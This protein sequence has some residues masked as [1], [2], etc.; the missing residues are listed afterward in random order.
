MPLC[1]SKA[2]WIFVNSLYK[3]MGMLERCCYPTSTY[4]LSCPTFKK[5]RAFVFF[6]TC[7]H[8]EVCPRGKYWYARCTHAPEQVGMG[9]TGWG[10][11]RAQKLYLNT[12]RWHPAIACLAR[13]PWYFVLSSVLGRG[14]VDLSSDSRVGCMRPHLCRTADMLTYKK[15]DFLFSIRVKLPSAEPPMEQFLETQSSF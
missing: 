11:C 1:P 5:R 9:C 14:N 13:I 7:V 3:T 2:S 15:E 8:W 12:M 10:L 6:S 4:Q